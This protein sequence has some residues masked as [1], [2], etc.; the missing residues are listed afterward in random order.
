[1]SERIRSRLSE[2]A[3]EPNKKG[4]ES[5]FRQFLSMRIGDYRAIYEIIWEDERVNILFI[6]H[7]SQ[8]YDD[9]ERSFL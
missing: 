4:K 5:A 3:E 9:F 7:R 1:M 6:G 8:V 2:L